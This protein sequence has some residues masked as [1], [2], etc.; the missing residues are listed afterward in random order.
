M[1]R[2]LRK[3][4]PAGRAAML[5]AVVAGALGLAGC[6]WYTSAVPLID[7]PG[8]DVVRGRQLLVEYGCISCH[9]IPGINRADTHVGPPLTEWARRRY[10]AG[11]LPNE[12]DNLIAWIVNPQEIEP[13]TAMPTLGVSPAEAADMAAYLYTLK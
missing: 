2:T 9:T 8:G 4:R 3:S 13:G 1:N 7:V 12:P 10:I 6:G 11:S 5:A